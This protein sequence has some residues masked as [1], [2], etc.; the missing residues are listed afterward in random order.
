M[1]E[2][3][4]SSKSHE[5]NLIR[6]LNIWNQVA[7]LLLS[8][9][10]DFI[11]LVVSKY[12]LSNGTICICS[13]ATCQPSCRIRTQISAASTDLTQYEPR[14]SHTEHTNHHKSGIA[15][16]SNAVSVLLILSGFQRG[17]SDHDRCGKSFSSW[18]E[19]N[20]LKSKVFRCSISQ[21]GRSC[22]CPVLLVAQK[23]EAGLYNTVFRC[24]THVSLSAF[25]AALV[26]RLIP[27]YLQWRIVPMLVEARLSSPVPEIDEQSSLFGP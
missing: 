19:A 16:F 21:L 26:A 8:T 27:E 18:D 13:Q 12:L 22:S 5:L 14:S 2:S 7:S 11:P 10:Q 1:T 17:L 6:F 3:V 25:A 20:G 4:S 23:A 9:V 24:W 15:S